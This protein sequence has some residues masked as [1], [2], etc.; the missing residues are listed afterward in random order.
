MKKFILSILFTSL[1][2]AVAQ[3]APNQADSCED[4]TEYHPQNSS[5]CV[6][7][8]GINNADPDAQVYCTAG[9]S[10]RRFN[11]ANTVHCLDRYFADVTG[12]DTDICKN[13]T[14][15]GAAAD[16][17]V[18]IDNYQKSPPTKDTDRECSEGVTTCI[19]NSQFEVT[20]PNATHD[21]DCNSLT[22]CDGDDD[23]FE[24]SGPGYNK[25]RVCQQ[26]QTCAD[27]QFQSFSN[28]TNFVGT[29]AF[30]KDRTCTTVGAACG[31][32][33]PP[34][35]EFAAATPRSDVDCREYTEC[36][37]GVNY[38][39]RPPGTD[40]KSNRLCAKEVSHACAA[41]TTDG[42]TT[43]T[44]QSRSFSKLHDRTCSQITVCGTNY[45]QTKAPEYDEILEMYTTNRVCSTQQFAMCPHSTGTDGWVTGFFESREPNATH[46]RGCA[47][48]S[49]CLFD[50]FELTPPVYDTTKSLYTSNRVCKEHTPPCDGSATVESQT[51]TRQ[52]DRV[53]KAMTICNQTLDQ[54]QT[55]TES[56]TV[57][58]NCFGRATCAIQE[59]ESNPVSDY[60]GSDL[61]SA[62][63][64]LGDKKNR[65][66]TPRHTC[67]S[68]QYESNP[69]SDY[70]N[71][72][73]G[74]R[75]QRTCKAWDVCGPVGTSTSGVDD[76]QTGS[77]GPQINRECTEQP[78]ACTFTEYEST[79]GDANNMR[80]CH[81]KKTGCGPGQFLLPSVNKESSPNVDNECDVCPETLIANVEKS[82]KKC[83][84]ICSTIDT[85]DFF[86][87]VKTECTT[88][89]DLDDVRG[90]YTK[91][92]FTFTDFSCDIQYYKDGQ[93]C[94]SCRHPSQGFKP[95]TNVICDGPGSVVSFICDP[96]FY[97]VRDENGEP[98]C[99][100]DN[101]PCPTNGLL[102]NIPV[103]YWTEFPVTCL[104]FT[105]TERCDGVKKRK[106]REV[107]TCIAPQVE[108]HPPNNSTGIF[109]SDRVCT[110]DGGSGGCQTGQY[111]RSGA[112]GDCAMC[113]DDITNEGDRTIATECTMST[114][115]VIYATACVTGFTIHNN[116][117]V[118]D[119]AVVEHNIASSSNCKFRK[120]SDI[121]DF[122]WTFIHDKNPNPDFANDIKFKDFRQTQYFLGKTT[123]T[124]ELKNF[125]TIK[126]SYK[127]YSPVNSAINNA[128]YKNFAK[129]EIN[130][131][132]EIFDIVCFVKPKYLDLRSNTYEPID[133]TESWYTTNG[134]TEV[135]YITPFTYDPLDEEWTQL[136]TT[137]VVSATAATSSHYTKTVGVSSRCGNTATTIQDIFAWSTL[138][139]TYS[140]LANFQLSIDLK[141]LGNG[142]NNPASIISYEYN[143][144]G[145]TFEGN[146]EVFDLLYIS[147]D[148]TS[149]D[150]VG[151]SAEDFVVFDHV[152][153][154]NGPDNDG[155]IQI[156]GTVSHKC[157]VDLTVVSPNQDFHCFDPTGIAARGS[158]SYTDELT[159]GHL[160]QGTSVSGCTAAL[161]SKCVPTINVAPTITDNRLCD[162]DETYLASCSLTIEALKTEIDV[163]SVIIDAIRLHD[164]HQ[165][166]KGHTSGTFDAEVFGPK[167]DFFTCDDALCT[168]DPYMI[169]EESSDTYAH[170]CKWYSSNSAQTES[171]SVTTP[172]RNGDDP[173]VFNSNC[174][175]VGDTAGSI[176]ET[177]IR[178]PGKIFPQFYVYGITTFSKQPTSGGLPP[179]TIAGSG[180]VLD[181]SGALQ[182]QP[183]Q[184]RLGG[185]RS[186]PP[187]VET[188]SVFVV[189]PQKVIAK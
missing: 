64:V 21:R 1:S 87:T 171:G 91:E 157:S 165:F 181:P 115:G 2:T 100:P 140:E 177:Q 182:Q 74:D 73:L 129:S 176:D 112:N 158:N 69:A 27:N 62:E 142:A 31:T 187:T 138:K 111:A 179:N 134:C 60:D 29:L 110:E 12:A 114:D 161:S 3:Q 148:Y 5:A 84:S 108:L 136:T 48:I 39:T 95:G 86:D 147:G 107:T 79:I 120:L 61:A 55:N 124:F 153:A 51:P 97:I 106:C 36:E 17:T 10:D 125:D 50:E 163:K 77:P 43:G 164:T 23:E 85:P 116:K 32:Q 135:K 174:D 45:F 38:E 75:V 130:S 152:I 154:P 128:T 59:Y 150:K 19:T 25:D 14:V 159:N 170:T 78:S 101:I 131:K 139:T 184:R 93:M 144:V 66:C 16:S 37:L 42:Y 133:I 94:K 104:D 41:V 47:A 119:T 118:F 172:G 102:N 123:A 53:C 13:E 63:G 57:D 22:T 98:S 44:W 88:T 24:F 4:P 18:G 83:E 126:N 175:A 68:G 9:A 49:E 180:P 82:S 56:S 151:T 40:G 96:G 20:P 72:V 145:I 15:C 46:D 89:L 156:V 143:T 183:G 28:K 90:V 52:Y 58:R 11:P 80:V 67:L 26:R 117:C 166:P 122:E 160:N 30:D 8:P 173:R 113:S 168:S 70:V 167:T 92:D 149:E 99:Q 185:T 71:G 132:D 33:E 189:S 162:D 7:C 141:K 35:W 76:Y 186:A 81:D 103:Q 54:W 109:T 65:V 34:K 146:V 188:K 6:P 178:L 121:F 137:P 169:L 155:D 127:Y 105:G